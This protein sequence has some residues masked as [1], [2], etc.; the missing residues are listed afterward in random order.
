MHKKKGKIYATLTEVKNQIG[1]VFAAV[2]EHG[3]VT[4]TSYNKE[5]YIISKVQPPQMPEIIE[6]VT[7]SKSTVSKQKPLRAEPPVIEETI[8]PELYEAPAPIMAT[9]Y[10][11]ERSETAPMILETEPEPQLIIDI[12]EIFRGISDAEVFT[13]NSDRELNWAQKARANL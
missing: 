3:A 1:D 13:R 11:S 9:T 5:K 2:D 6:D 10:A 12:F 4:I 7:H 8:V